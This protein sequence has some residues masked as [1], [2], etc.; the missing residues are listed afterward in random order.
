MANDEHVTEI[1]L[2]V[3]TSEPPIAY[4]LRSKG[5]GAPERLEVEILGP[6]A[7]ARLEI[8]AEEARTWAGELFAAVS[9]AYREATGDPHALSDEEAAS[10][11]AAGTGYMP[12]PGFNLRADDNGPARVRF[13][14]VVEIAGQSLHTSLL[15]E[16]LVN[17]MTRDF[18]V[19]RLAVSEGEPL[20]GSLDTPR[21]TASLP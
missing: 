10:L 13:T 8:E 6:T 3:D 21:T 11:G 20:S 5:S 14:V 18:N 2:A 9:Q 12:G 4:P 16:S 19:D 17:Q 15:R 1:W 7:T